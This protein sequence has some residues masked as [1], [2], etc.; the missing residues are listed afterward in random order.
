MQTI[1]D[2]GDSRQAYDG[3]SALLSQRKPKSTE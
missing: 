1:D 2:K 3:I